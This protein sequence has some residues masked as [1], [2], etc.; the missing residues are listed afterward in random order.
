M[1]AWIASHFGVLGCWR[2]PDFSSQLDDFRAAG[3]EPIGTGHHCGFDVKW[4]RRRCFLPGVGSPGSK[5]ELKVSRSVRT[6]AKT[7]RNFWRKF[8]RKGFNLAKLYLTRYLRYAPTLAVL[9]LFFMSSF[10]LAI[11]DGLNI[12]VLENMIHHCYQY[13]WSSLLMVQ[14]YVNVYNIVSW[15]I[16]T[17]I[18]TWWWYRDRKFQKPWSRNKG[19]SKISFFFVSSAWT[20]HGTWMSTS[21][22]SC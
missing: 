1:L 12:R 15:G 13:W 5:V 16:E 10:Q 22:S 21:S 8:F 2:P 14:N 11:V 18:I 20:S 4:L 17:I 9:L 19:N 3:V 7:F 6:I